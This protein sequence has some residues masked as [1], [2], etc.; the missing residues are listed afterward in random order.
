MCW[1]VVVCG[2]QL[3]VVTDRSG[4]RRGPLRRADPAPLTDLKWLQL[5]GA[6]KCEG[7]DWGGGGGGPQT[8]LL[9]DL[10]RVGARKMSGA[11]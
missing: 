10:G 3:A 6:A 11:L 7:G 9:T 1:D 2:R 4:E 5:T 8:S